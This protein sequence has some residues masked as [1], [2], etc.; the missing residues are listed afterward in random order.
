M[1]ASMVKFA[2]LECHT[3]GNKSMDRMYKREESVNVYENQ[4]AKDGGNV[5]K[6]VRRVPYSRAG[7]DWYMYE[8]F[9]FP[10]YVDETHDVDACIILTDKTK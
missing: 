8:N 10:G 1:P 3:I 9:C 4:A 5:L 7:L 2:A 6:T